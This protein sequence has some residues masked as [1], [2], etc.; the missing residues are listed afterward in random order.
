MTGQT[1]YYA[2]L[3]AEDIVARQYT[4]ENCQIAA[5]RWRGTAGEID[6]IFRQG[7]ALIFVEVKKSKTFDRAVAALSKRQQSRIYTAASEYLEHEP[8]G[9]NTEM[10]FDVALV[11]RTGDVRII[12][13]AF[14]QF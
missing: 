7:D 3:Y 4:A 8:N 1:S 2:G 10:R 5:K 9:Q 12:Q 14:G 13:N 6:L 11:D